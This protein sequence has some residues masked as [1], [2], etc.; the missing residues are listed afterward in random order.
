MSYLYATQNISLK[1][2][3]IVITEFFKFFRGKNQ[4]I[5]VTEVSL[6]LK[7]L[8]LINLL[9]SLINLFSFT[10]ATLNSNT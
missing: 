9:R 4:F 1:I 6:E 10:N 2:K 3:K 5:L 8:I 7:N